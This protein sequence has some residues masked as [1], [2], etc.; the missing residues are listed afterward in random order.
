MVTE[1]PEI[2]KL[3]GKGLVKALCGFSNQFTSRRLKEE[4]MLKSAIFREE[5]GLMME[6]PR[7][8]CW[9]GSTFV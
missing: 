7:V 2:G 5:R 1:T 8:T 3:K 9:P 6:I 4:L